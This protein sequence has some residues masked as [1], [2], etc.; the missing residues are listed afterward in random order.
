[1]ALIN[2]S[3]VTGVTVSDRARVHIGPHIQGSHIEHHVHLD[4]S[5]LSATEQRRLREDA[6]LSSLAFSEM[7][8]REK[9]VVDACEHTFEWAFEDT[10]KEQSKRRP[11]PN[12]L[13]VWLTRENGVFYIIGK[14]GAGKSTF[15]RYLAGH[16][17]TRVLLESWAEASGCSL[18]IA[19]HF[20]WCSG[21]KMQASQEGL[22]RGLL[23]TVLSQHRTL[24]SSIFLHRL[25][26]ELLTL[27]NL[28]EQSWERRDLA[29]ALTQLRDHMSQQK[30]AMCLFIDGLDEFEGDEVTLVADI[31]QLLMSPLIKICASSRPRNLFER[32][33]GHKKC[34][35]KLTL[36]TCTRD[37]IA[38]SVRV[39]LCGDEAFALA[40]QSNLRREDFIN[41][42]SDRA[43]GV[44]LW[45]VL[46]VREL[47]REAHHY[48]SVHELEATLDKLPPEL[49][50]ND[51]LFQHIVGRSDA[52]YRKYMARLLLVMQHSRLMMGGQTI[53]W[54]QWSDAHFLFKDEQDTQFASRGCLELD[55]RYRMPSQQ[56]NRLGTQTSYCRGLFLECHDSHSHVIGASC[57]VDERLLIEDTRLQIRKWCPDFVD[58]TVDHPEFTHRSIA[59]YLRT[60]EVQRKM[61]TLAGEGFQP[62]LTLCRLIFAHSRLSSIY[63]NSIQIRSV[64]AVTWL[65][66]TQRDFARSILRD[67]ERIQIHGQDYLDWE[68]KKHY[69]LKI[70]NDESTDLN[71]P[72]SLIDGL[73]ISMCQQKHAW[74]LVLVARRGAG[75]FV[76]DEWSCM[77]ESVRQGVGTIIIIG[78]VRHHTKSDCLKEGIASIL[79]HIIADGIS[80][81]RVYK[82]ARKPSNAGDHEFELTLWQALICTFW[83]TWGRDDNVTDWNLDLVEILLDVSDANSKVALPGLDPSGMLKDR[84]SLFA[85]MKPRLSTSEGGESDS[86]VPV[87]SWRKNAPR[88]QSILASHG[89]LTSDERKLAEQGR[90]ITDAINE[91]P[92]SDPATR[93]AYTIAVVIDEPDPETINQTSLTTAQSP[94]PTVHTPEPLHKRLGRW[95]TKILP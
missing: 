81:N 23:L 39:S 3:S 35:F 9:Q 84:T 42:V 91:G 60:P 33:F 63:I 72:L 5:H 51:G 89:L 49:S 6:I 7:I 24:I 32:A 41:K 73:D 93:A 11:R 78:L 85:A 71:L 22:W 52:R 56:C 28:R 43:D 55:E 95:A 54:L 46:V 47:L 82:W 44:F 18:L 57:K 37:D 61:V 67:F 26:N 83:S 8:N 25:E 2:H 34:N 77:P 30:L 70:H 64:L 88:L 76:E 19:S 45:A 40:V 10:L 59:D 65:D 75:W 74:F 92:P 58:T 12:L 79:K 62:A 21:S 14:A 27:T 86:S 15:M 13:P 50:G 4:Q 80:V 20:F 29:D 17:K 1:M 69:W 53:L 66:T 68:L 94:A 31:K 16:P 90:L 48:G 87:S 38:E 36:Q